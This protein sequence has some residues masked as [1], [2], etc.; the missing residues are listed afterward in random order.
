MSRQQSW[1]VHNMAMNGF[2]RVILTFQEKLLQPATFDNCAL[3]TAQNLMD[4]LEANWRAYTTQHQ[5]I[6]EHIAALDGDAISLDA[7]FEEEVDVVARVFEG[8]KAIIE[9][10]IRALSKALVKYT[11]KPNEITVASF[12]GEY[13]EYTAFRAAVLARVM[14]GDYPPHSKIDIIT[15]ALKGEAK[16]HIGEIRGQDQDELD[17]IW[18]ALEDTYYNP[19][20]L[21]R[22]HIGLIIDTPTITKGSAASYR[23]LIG[24]VTQNLHGLTQLQIPVG[25]LDPVILEIVLRKLDA[26]GV[27]FWE[28]TR[29][30]KELPSLKVLLDFLESRIVVLSNTAHQSARVK[31]KEEPQEQK[32][33]EHRQND[34]RNQ[35]NRSR[36]SHSGKF[37]KRESSLQSQE[38][39]H[40]RQ[41][42]GEDSNQASNSSARS[43][44]PD[45]CVMK[46][47]Y[48]RPHFLWMC[49]AFRAL[50]L[51]KRSQLIKD[52][53]L[54]RRCITFTHSIEDCKSP[55]CSDCKDDVHNQML[56]PKFMIIAKTN[57]TRPSSAKRRRNNKKG[58]TNTE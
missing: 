37:N 8:V 1:A 51:E 35:N 44:P 25:Q 30:S 18:R 53:K 26:E 7:H 34:Q 10:K 28:T 57:T 11:P 5:R 55:R 33:A 9:A 29:P 6:T 19:Y 56:C 58:S 13:H 39:H 2:K 38:P 14:H 54:C 4:R 15:S 52:N 21:M 46:C 32:S 22:S 12:S 48:K 31:P 47:D 42:T 27:A 40:K 49:R 3:S 36:D 41:R 24:T 17:R 50:E 45:K 23:A 20:L 43:T 16:K